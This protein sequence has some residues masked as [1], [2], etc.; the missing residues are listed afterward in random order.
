MFGS[1]KTSLRCRDLL[2]SP[3]MRERC[4]RCEEV[5]TSL[6]PGARISLIVH[7]TCIHHEHVAPVFMLNIT[8]LRPQ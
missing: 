3:L 8:F 2:A 1:A 7:V 5:L 4:P 6:A